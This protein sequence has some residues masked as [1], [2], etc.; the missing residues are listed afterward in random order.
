MG[1]R[2]GIP[3]WFSGGAGSDFPG[4]A[5]GNQPVKPRG[6]ER[7]FLIYSLPANIPKRTED[8]LF[9]L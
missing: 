3:D 5:G 1:S 6:G 2:R 7:Y 4:V 8:L 9:A